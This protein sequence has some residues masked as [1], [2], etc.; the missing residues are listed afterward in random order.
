MSVINPIPTDTNGQT[1]ATGSLQALG[2][3]EFLQLLVA[4]LENQDPLNPMDDEDFIADLAQFSSLEQMYNISE[5]IGQS[6]DLDLL[7]MQSLNNVM[8]SGLIGNDI[9]ASY[10]SVYIEDG[11]EP[12]MSYTLDDYA[13]AV[14]FTIT[15]SEGTVVATL[16]EQKMEAGVHNLKWDGTDS[17]G[18]RVDDGLY[19]VKALATAPDGT[20]SEVDMSLVGAVEQVLYRDGNA[21]LRVNGVEIP[22]GDV[23]AVGQPG[24]FT[25]QD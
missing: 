4:K 14:S 1:K 3:D 18:N 17:R 9:R 16:T 10:S 6:N 13:E 8:A 21:Y 19:T 15:D 23:S 7:Q 12:S 25:Q 11:N 24:A 2:K 22:L 20:S 5:A